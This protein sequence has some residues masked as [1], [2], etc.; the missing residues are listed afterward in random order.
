MNMPTTNQ[1]PLIERISALAEPV[2]L[3]TLRLL[4]REELSVGEV[5]R[6]LQLPQST[7]SRHLKVL[8]EAG[9]AARRSDGPATLYRLVLDDLPDA[10]R[11]L[12]HAVREQ[13]A[14]LPEAGDDTR[15]LKDVLAERRLDSRAFFGKFGGEWDELRSGLFGPGLTLHALLALIPSDWI[16]ADLGC[17]TGNAAELL[18]PV[19]KQVVCVDQSE[20]MLDA[21]RK[22]LADHDNIEYRLGEL[23]A[24]PMADG[25][26]DAAVCLLVLHH[27]TQ[28]ARALREMRR[29]IRPGGVLLVVDM[30]EH[31]RSEYRHT[32]GHI[33]LGFHPEEFAETLGAVGFADPH[34]RALPSSTDARGPGTFVAT[35]RTP[36]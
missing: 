24:M 26:V 10:D 6:V 28:P 8:A 3:R 29:I 5:A 20:A 12:W 17:G 14:D 19:V 32:M 22:R 11:P 7:V 15:R 2:R 33:H 4:E 16:V 23:D 21:A 9:W 18:A 35:A 31:N 13:V 34:A 36:A 27:L 1:T 30:I 25:A